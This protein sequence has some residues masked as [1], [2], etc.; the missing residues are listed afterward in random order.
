[1]A[2]LDETKSTI[3][4]AILLAMFCASTSPTQAQSTG[5]RPLSDILDPRPSILTDDFD[6]IRAIARQQADPSSTTDRI[7][8]ES[9]RVETVTFEGFVFP[10]NANMAIFSDDGCSVYINGQ[11]LP[12][13]D[14]AGRTRTCGIWASRFAS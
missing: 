13:Q 4:P 8:Y 9:S 2:I 12:N 3:W 5:A 1:M 6:G 7:K 11:L 14:R 10:I